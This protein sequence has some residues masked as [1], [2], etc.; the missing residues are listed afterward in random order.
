[1]AINLESYAIGSKKTGTFE[2]SKEI[3][4]APILSLMQDGG[5]LLEDLSGRFGLSGLFSLFGLVRRFLPWTLAPEPCQYLPFHPGPAFDPVPGVLVEPADAE[6]QPQEEQP[7]H[8]RR[9][10]VEHLID[11]VTHVQEEHR[12]NHDRKPPGADHKDV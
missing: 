9:R 6:R 8:E 7:Q 3:K 11:Q 4:K 12:G 2:Q 10:R 5:F 1:M